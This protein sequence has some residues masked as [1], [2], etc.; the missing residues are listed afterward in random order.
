MGTATAPHLTG[1]PQNVCWTHL[2]MWRLTALRAMQQL[3]PLRLMSLVLALRPMSS[4]I[5]LRAMWHLRLL[6]NLTATSGLLK[7]PSKSSPTRQTAAQ[8]PCWLMHQVSTSPATTQ[9]AL[10]HQ[11]GCTLQMMQL[12]SKDPCRCR[13]WGSTCSY[14]SGSSSGSRLPSS[15]EGANSTQS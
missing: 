4:L 2:C 10:A 5:S 7:G 13:P 3:R 1:E 15:W 11:A 9:K 6:S 8:P 14:N 12:R